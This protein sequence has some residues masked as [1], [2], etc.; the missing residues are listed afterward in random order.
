M[1]W[2]GGLALELLRALHSQDTMLAGTG[3]DMPE[4][5]AVAILFFWLIDEYALYETSVLRV[6]GGVGSPKCQKAGL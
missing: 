2:R 6:G 5:L 1:S 3:C 4:V